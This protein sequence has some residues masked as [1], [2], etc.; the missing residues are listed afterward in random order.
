MFLNTKLSD[1]FSF[2]SHNCPLIVGETVQSFPNIILTNDAIIR[3]LL[4]VRTNGAIRGVARLTR[5]ISYL[6]LETRIAKENVLMRATPEET[7]YPL[8]RQTANRLASDSAAIR[9]EF[10]PS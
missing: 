9:R 2:F 6:F 7:F 3:R 1:F 10:I 4:A 8:G 5:T